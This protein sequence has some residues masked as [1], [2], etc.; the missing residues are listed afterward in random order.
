M[1][2]EGGAILSSMKSGIKVFLG[3]GFMGVKQIGEDH[4]AR[5]FTKVSFLPKKGFAWEGKLL[6]FSC[7]SHSKKNIIKNKMA[8][9]RKES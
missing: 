2:G 9:Q 8:N 5:Q 3:F 4:I 7:M 1:A 6:S